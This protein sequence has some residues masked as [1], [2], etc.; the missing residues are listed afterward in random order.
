MTVQ[1]TQYNIFQ[2]L[3]SARLVDT[4]NLSGNYLNGPL[5][6]GL[7]ATLTAA[8]V[9]V[10]TIDSVVANLND[11][12]L[13]VGQSNANEN[14]VYVV[15]QAGGASAVWVLTRSADQQSIEQLK[16]GQFLSVSAGTA[17]AGSM[18]VLVEPL[19]GALG[20][21]DLNFSPSSVPSGDTFLVAANNLDDLDSVPTALTN[22]GLSPT[23]DVVFSSVTVDN[24]GLHILDTNATHD[25]I[26]TPGS[27]LTAD[28]VLTLT[29]GDAARTLDISAASVTISS[30]A[31]TVL[32]DANAAAVR[33]TVGAQSSANIIAAHSADI[34]GAGAG[35]IDVTVAGLTSSS[36]VVATILSSSNAVAVAKA[37]AATGKF[38]IT[39][40]ADPGAA[41]VINYVAFVAAQ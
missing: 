19:P 11:R 22:L 36:V 1:T 17:D 16:A 18:Y 20:I 29:T 35:P 3:T 28:R 33:T 10:L 40:S 2:Q 23:D 8:S 26:I 4:A 7:G 41:C 21:D 37:V 6:N 5:N 14:G 30:F 27:N 25:L 15:T 13:L 38:S 34:G 31:A 9:G 39:F 24:D 32:D 12:I